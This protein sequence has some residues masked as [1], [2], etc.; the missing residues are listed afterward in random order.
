MRD[1]SQPSALEAPGITTLMQQNN[2]MPLNKM[3]VNF[4]HGDIV[5]IP[6]HCL[7]SVPRYPRDAKLQAEKPELCCGKMEEVY[8]EIQDTVEERRCT[9]NSDCILRVKVIAY[10]IRDYI[11]GSVL[12]QLIKEQGI[13]LAQGTAADM[14]SIG[15]SSYS[16]TW[17]QLESTKERD[18]E[19]AMQ[20]KTGVELLE[21]GFH[22]CHKIHNTLHIL[23]SGGLLSSVSA[24]H[25]EPLSA[26][27]MWQKE[28]RANALN[29][30]ITFLH[31]T[32]R[33]KKQHRFFL[34]WYNTT[35]LFRARVSIVSSL[36]CCDVS[37]GFFYLCIAV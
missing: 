2:A 4:A 13:N 16:A 19:V 26:K 22:R 14:R 28:R 27:V 31:R 30:I 33:L 23:G 34:R 36:M 25:V 12:K 37:H 10:V 15:N 11:D 17:Q 20:L 8:A 29:N 9:Q 3:N 18:E 6:V 21:N 24:S 35:A 7:D 32:I 1:L 5:I